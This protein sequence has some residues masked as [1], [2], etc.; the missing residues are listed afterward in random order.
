MLTGKPLRP[1]NVFGQ[2][3]ATHGFPFFLKEKSALSRF[4]LGHPFP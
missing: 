3:K 1:K 2:P 4:Q